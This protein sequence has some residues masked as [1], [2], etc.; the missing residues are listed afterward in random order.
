MTVSHVID[1][2]PTFGK[3]YDHFVE[4]LRDPDTPGPVLSAKRFSQA[5]PDVGRPGTCPPQ[6]DQPR[7]D[8]TGRA[9]VFARGLEGHQSRHRHFRG[10]EPGALLVSK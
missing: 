2:P 3:D 10:R 4:Y 5:S 6:H 1:P 9:A 7:A 8:L